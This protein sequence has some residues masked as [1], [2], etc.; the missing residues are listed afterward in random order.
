MVD[1]LDRWVSD[2]TPATDA[3]VQTGRR[4]ALHAAYIASDTL[5]LEPHC[6]RDDQLPADRAPSLL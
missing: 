4:A 3:L 6:I 5:L 1:L 2:G